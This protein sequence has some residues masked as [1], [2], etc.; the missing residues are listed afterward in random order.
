MGDCWSRI[1]IST[2]RL[3]R[4]FQLGIA[5]VLASTS[6]KADDPALYLEGGVGQ[7]RG[8][9]GTP[10]TSQLSAAYGTMGYASSTYDLSVT[11]PILRLDV[12][13]NGQSTSATGM[14]DVLIRGIRRF[15]PE[16]NSGFAFDGG[17]ALKLPTA[18]TDKG[19]GTGKADVGGFIAAHQRWNRLQIT[20]LGGWVQSGSMGGTASQ[21]TRSGFY[22]VGTGLSY[23]LDRTKWSLAFEA[24]GS[25]YAGLAGAREVS[26]GMFHLM[27]KRL[28]LRGSVSAGLSDGSPKTGFGLGVVYWP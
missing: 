7:R 10:V 16:T 25:Q 12:S 11:L 2:N 22:A 1:S 8:D 13:G 21:S 24:R 5:L 19:L 18:N 23:Y 20:L 4:V 14:G 27:S 6:L 17:L 9:F 15:V 26:L 28:G 3:H